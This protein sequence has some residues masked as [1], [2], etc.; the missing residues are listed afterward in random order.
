[1]DLG[2]NYSVIS[3][4]IALESESEPESE[5]A[6]AT[7][8][9]HDRGQGEGGDDA[10]DTEGKE[11]NQLER[12]LSEGSQWRKVIVSGCRIIFF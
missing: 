6:D 10:K 2:G 8:K 11:D 9:P 5:S 1:M 3:R 7:R 4:A 12:Q